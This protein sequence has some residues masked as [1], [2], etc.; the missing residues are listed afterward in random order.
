MA[1]GVQVR[2]RPDLDPV[3]HGLSFTVKGR[4]KVRHE[5]CA[6]VESLNAR[7]FHFNKPLP[8]VGVC[9][10]TGCGK[11]TLFMTLYRIVEPCAGRIVIDGVDISTIGLA[12]L[13]CKLSLV[14][15]V[16]GHLAQDAPSD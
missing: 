15:Q 7:L 8:Q 10:R 13:R 3:L 11:S 1:E 14:P 4:N 5:G 6:R 16:R 9:G 12:D 2:Y